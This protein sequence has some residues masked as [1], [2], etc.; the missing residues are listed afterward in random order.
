MKRLLAFGL[1]L[2]AGLLNGCGSDNSL[3][4]GPDNQGAGAAATIIELLTSSPQL[5]SD[6][7]G[8]TT[9]TLTAIAKDN[10]NNVV[11]GA[12]VGFNATSGS[13]QITQGTTDA[14]GI[15]IATLSNGNDAGN[16]T[17]TV[18]ATSGGASAT[19]NILVVGTT[20]TISGPVSLGITDSGV[21]TV[22]L[23]DSNGAGIPNQTV[24][25][26]S[27]N[28]NTLSAPS[29]QTG[30]DGEVQVTLTA[31]VGGDDTLTAMA[32]GL[33]T[34]RLVSVAPDAFVITSPLEGA[35]IPLGTAQDIVANWTVSG[36]PQVG[37]TI[38]FTST[39]G[40]L[41]A[42]AAD[43]D[44]AG[45]TTVPAPVN[46][47]S[48]S[49]GPGVLTALT[50]TGISTSL[51]VEFVA[52]TV[53]SIATQASPTN[54]GT[55]QQSEISAVVRDP[56]GN[57]VKNQIVNFELTDFTG[58]FLSVASSVT[59]SQGSAQTFY[60]GGSVASAV[61][62]VQI[63]AYVGDPVAP[64]A[65]NTVSLTVAQQ[66]LFVQIGTGNDLSE[67]TGA[68]FAKE[69]NIFVTDALGNPVSNSP[70][71]VSVLSE[72]YRK[73]FLVLGG[74]PQQ[75]V[76]GP[77][78]PVACLDEDVNRDGI[79]Q[80]AEDAN[81]SGVIEAGNVATVAA[82]PVSAPG[83]DN[84]AS[85]GAAGTSATATTNGLGIARVCV[86][87]PQNFNLWVVAT[88]EARAS[89][90]GT[91]GSSSQ[92][93]LLDAKAEDITNTS[94]NPPG[95]NSPFGADLVVDCNPVP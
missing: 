62:G 5:Q 70:V 14:N 9:V 83:D 3:A 24:T 78:V 10:T 34:T 59:D 31:D 45:D 71:Q 33:T 86:I 7:T 40:T 46:V 22:L 55:G 69:W 15:A 51:N 17:I 6:Q 23:E 4:D 76:Y 20:L 11:E 48:N 63:R 88:I 28:S 25:I 43:T 61:D 27:A 19:I 57:L 67:P 30:A 50:P 64:D 13:I 16:R 49:A 65:E 95:V 29:L 68:S 58:G 91:E 39:R 81:G 44:G 79:L 35:E 36:V 32:I 80:P 38:S 72:E 82:V 53:N 87:Y 42:G 60:T 84:C 77:G 8:A 89:V 54:V 12:V 18:T 92:S 21:Y 56:A 2:L 41:S 26:D 73:G 74:D 75:W 93:F 1:I 94:A 85:A 66:T 90:Q 52:T 47:T 37:Q